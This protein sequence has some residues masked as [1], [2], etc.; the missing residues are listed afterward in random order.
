[1]L[2]PGFQAIVLS[3]LKPL[4]NNFEY[5]FNQKQKIFRCKG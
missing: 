4:R 5:S 1:M 3:A 2:P